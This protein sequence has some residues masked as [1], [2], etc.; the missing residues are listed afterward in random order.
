[1]DE[2]RFKALHSLFKAQSS[3]GCMCVGWKGFF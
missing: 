1:M 2:K 3:H